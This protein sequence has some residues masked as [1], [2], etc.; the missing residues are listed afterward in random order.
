LDKSGLVA[1]INQFTLPIITLP[2]IVTDKA[3]SSNNEQLAFA[4]QLSTY[5]LALKELDAIL[6]ANKDVVCEIWAEAD[7]I[8]KL[9]TD[10][11]WAELELNNLAKVLD[12]L[13]QKWKAATEQVNY[14]YSNMYW[15]QSRFPDAL[16]TDVIGLCKV[17]NKKEYTEEQDYSLNAGRYVGVEIEGD[18]ISKEDFNNKI[19]T[20]LNQFKKLSEN[21]AKLEFEVIS[22]LTEFLK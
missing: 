22:K 18:E 14:W 4:E 12:E 1:K 6:K 8:L 9:K 16:Y 11:T 3:I 10:K 13:Q 21:S 5:V 7:K 20:S 2:I 17:A 15:L 19:N